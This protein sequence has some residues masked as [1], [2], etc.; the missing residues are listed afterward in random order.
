M[1]AFFTMASRMDSVSFST[2][3]RAG[4]LRT[5]KI[6]PYRWARSA[7]HSWINPGPNRYPMTG[8]DHGPG[9]KFFGRLKN[10]M[11]NLSKIVAVQA[12]RT[13]GTDIE[14]IFSEVTECTNSYNFSIIMYCAHAISWL[15]RSQF[16]MYRSMYRAMYVH[17][18][19][20]Y[21]IDVFHICKH[22]VFI[23]QRSVVLVVQRAFI[24][25]LSFCIISGPRRWN[26]VAY[27][28]MA[29]DFHCIV[30]NK[31]RLFT[32]W[33]FHNYFF[34]PC[35]SLKTPPLSS[36]VQCSFL[37]PFI[38]SFLFPFPTLALRRLIYST[39]A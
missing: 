4:P 38:C 30:V 23:S 21:T 2:T 10:E 32:I 27:T 20:V 7:K 5:L 25:S 35:L 36:L 3:I 28:W 33:C 6:G 37:P 9:G 16:Y 22:W 13:E 12:T 18:T 26:R 11:S 19:F 8:R 24:N 14:N 29:E 17:G 31:T 15:E 1:S 39:T 34:I